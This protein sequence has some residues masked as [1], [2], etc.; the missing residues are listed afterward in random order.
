MTWFLAT[1]TFAKQNNVAPAPVPPEENIK[2]EK[3]DI[4]GH[5][6]FWTMPTFPLLQNTG[7]AEL[8]P[9]PGERFRELIASPMPRARYG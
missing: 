7:L 5:R 8:F 4:Q 3:T 6:C 1:H 2:K 9:V